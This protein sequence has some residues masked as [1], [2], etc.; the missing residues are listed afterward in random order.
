MEPD[1]FTFFEN[2]GKLILCTLN[3]LDD[4][5]CNACTNAIMKISDNQPSFNVSV[6]SIYYL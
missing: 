2:P 4:P 5:I 1:T 6:T 3:T